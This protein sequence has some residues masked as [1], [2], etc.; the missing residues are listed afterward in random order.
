M[1]FVLKALRP[2]T[3]LITTAAIIDSRISAPNK[4][5]SD[6]NK[7]ITK[8]MK[9]IETAREIRLETMLLFNTQV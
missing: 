1:K 8:A 3:N 2:P 9:P 6:G 7:K 5:K 4:I